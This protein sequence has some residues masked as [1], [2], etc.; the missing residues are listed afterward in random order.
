M[1]RRRLEESIDR[2]IRDIRKDT[3]PFGGVVVVFGDDF[4][5]IPPVAMRGSM[6]QIVAASTKRS[7]VWA[8][9]RRH[10]LAR[11]A[12]LEEGEGGFAKY[13][14][15]I[16]DGEESIAAGEDYIELLVDICADDARVSDP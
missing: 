10:R 5:Q 1:S 4:R 2:S 16:G 14:S 8:S 15:Q 12:R 13:L 9:M 11:N 6:A 7:P 3:R